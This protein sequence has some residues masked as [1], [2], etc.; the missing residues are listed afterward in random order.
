MKFQSPSVRWCVR[1]FSADRS[2][3]DILCQYQETLNVVVLGTNP[4]A[5]VTGPIANWIPSLPR[6]KSA[7]EQPHFLC[8]F[9]NRSLYSRFVLPEPIQRPECSWENGQFRTRNAHWT[10]LSSMDHR[11]QRTVGSGMRRN[12]KDPLAA[13]CG[14]V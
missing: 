10:L 4:A 2:L 3:Q 13:K 12:R 6:K 11:S 9:V 8:F 5:N 1:V 7:H 14:A